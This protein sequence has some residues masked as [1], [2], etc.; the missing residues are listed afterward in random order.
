VGARL[1][2]PPHVFHNALTPYKDLEDQAWGA[3]LVLVVLVLIVNLASRFALR[4]QLALAG[5]GTN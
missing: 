5:R 3:A 4:R 2:T 1:A